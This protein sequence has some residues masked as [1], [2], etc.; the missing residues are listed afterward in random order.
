MF[1]LSKLFGDPCLI[2]TPGRGDGWGHRSHPPGWV[3][4]ELQIE[5]KLWHTLLYGCPGTNKVRTCGGIDDYYYHHWGCETFFPW[6]GQIDSDIQFLRHATPRPEKCPKPGQCNPTPI[7]VKQGTHA[8]WS[9]GKSWGVRLYLAGPD[10]GAPSTMQRLQARRIPNPIGPIEVLDPRPRPPVSTPTKYWAPTGVTTS[11]FPTGSMSVPPI[12]FQ[13]PLLRTLGSVFSLL[14]D[15]NPE[16]TTEC[17]LCLDPTPPYYVGI[18]ANISVGNSVAL[19]RNLTLY[20]EKEDENM[21]IP[22]P[23]SVSRFP[24]ISP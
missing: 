22:R 12:V 4:D 2:L 18:A 21:R 17:W 6:K 8:S 10:H 5:R 23:S 20:D 16:S 3:C 13:H 14:N 9:T 19:S 11:A 24:A 15:S 7:I 1:D